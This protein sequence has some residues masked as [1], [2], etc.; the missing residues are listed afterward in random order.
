MNKINI[1]S[2]RVLQMLSLLFTKSYTMNELMDKLS[3]VTGENCSNFLVSK[4]INT[5]RFCGIDIQKI[6]GKYTLLKLPFGLD[7]SDE[8]LRLLGDIRCFCAGMRVSKNVRNINTLLQKINQR[9]DKYY[10]RVNVPEDDENIVKF[11]DA[12]DKLV[13]IELKYTENNVSHSILCEP[14]EYNYE[15][16]LL[17]F[18]V[19]HNGDR[20]RIYHSDITSITI[21]NIKASKNLSSASVVFQLKDI[22]AKRYTLRAGERIVATNDD[23]SINV[24]NKTEDKKALLHRLLKY[25]KLCEV[26]SP[27]HYKKEMLSIIDKTLE[28]YK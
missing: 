20:K 25:G 9:T 24:L 11:E 22:L 15:N 8:E 21:T 4:Y 17:G 12:L 5:C 26:M 7:F 19:N 14:L 16:N 2:M 3:E 1:S 13:K 28:N 18:V 10:A 6:N 27:R 23:G